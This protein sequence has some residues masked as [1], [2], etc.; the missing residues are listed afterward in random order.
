AP[1]RDPRA[2]TRRGSAGGS[3]RRRERRRPRRRGASTSP[4]PGSEPALLEVALAEL[5]FLEALV[6]ADVRDL[7]HGAAARAGARH[8]D[9]VRHRNHAHVVDLGLRDALLRVGLAVVE[10]E[11]GRHEVVLAEP[12]DDALVADVLALRGQLDDVRGGA[13]DRLLAAQARG[14]VV[15]G[16]RDHLLEEVQVVVAQVGADEALAAGAR[17]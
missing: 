11:A 2:R 1:R 17:G 6:E 3:A 4:G 12:D 15:L 10:L 16:P 8:L 13:V 14:G 7:D 9:G 5:V